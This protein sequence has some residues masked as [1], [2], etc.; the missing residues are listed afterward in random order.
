MIKRIEK[1]G[2]KG[3]WEVGGG[4]DGRKEEIERNLPARTVTGR[5]SNVPAWLLARQR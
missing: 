5:L 3:R 1:I 2:A 4:S